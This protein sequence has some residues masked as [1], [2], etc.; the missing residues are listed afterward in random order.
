[1]TENGELEGIVLQERYSQT[2]GADGEQQNKYPLTDPYRGDFYTDAVQGMWR[3]GGCVVVLAL[4]VGLSALLGVGS[5]SGRGS[6]IADNVLREHECPESVEGMA[7]LVGEKRDAY[8]NRNGIKEGSI[9]QG[10]FDFG[11]RQT[12]RSRC[13]SD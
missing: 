3:K 13:N 1:M 10:F 8:F 11:V 5:Y 12:Y 2:S 4:A 7:P 9:R 6:I